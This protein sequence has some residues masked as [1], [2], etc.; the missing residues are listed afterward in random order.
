MNNW[1]HTGINVHNVN[2]FYVTFYRKNIMNTFVFFILQI[3]TVANMYYRKMNR[4]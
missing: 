3:D 2:M 4:F 1:F